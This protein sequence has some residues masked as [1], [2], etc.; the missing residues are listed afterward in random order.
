MALDGKIETII[1]LPHG[2]IPHWQEEMALVILSQ[3]NNNIQFIDANQP[4]FSKRKGRRN[5]IYRYEEI[6]DVALNKTESPYSVSI[7]I[8]EISP[9]NLSSRYY[10]ESVRKGSECQSLSEIADTI[11]RA[12]RLGGGV[13][14]DKITDYQEL[15][16][17]DIRPNQFTVN[18][19]KTKRG[20]T[21]RVDAFR[22]MPYD[23]LLPL[24]G[25]PTTVGILGEIND[26][27]V[28][29][30]GI[31]TIRLKDR[32]KVKAL[33]LYLLS[34]KGQD[35]LSRLYEASPNKTINPDVLGTLPVVAELGEDGGKFSRLTEL[36]KQVEDM[37]KEI[38]E[39]L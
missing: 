19:S 18:V 34:K 35:A 23:I 25:G 26:I 1:S 9:E 8:D 20:S 13:K 2:I 12:Q 4:Y 30:A 14:D 31:I 32:G 38:I 33:Y 36:Q 7:S 22:S 16:I 15:M 24:R 3:G 28:A 27:V 21:R 6:I 17:H 29:N 11:F 5:T 10:I 37:E 39:I